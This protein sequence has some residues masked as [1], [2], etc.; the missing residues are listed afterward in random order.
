MVEAYILNLADCLLVYF[1]EDMLRMWWM[2]EKRRNVLS[3]YIWSRRP[4]DWISWCFIHKFTPW[5]DTSI[6]TVTITWSRGH[7]AQNTNQLT[8]KLPKAKN[9]KSDDFLQRPTNDSP[10]GIPLV[11]LESRH[12][13]RVMQRSSFH[14][15]H[16]ECRCRTVLCA[17]P[18]GYTS[19][20]SEDEHSSSKNVYEKCVPSRMI[21][22]IDHPQSPQWLENH[23]TFP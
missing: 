6:L 11:A 10:T 13:L 22:G 3:I 20:I 17:G 23:N 15:F 4:L 12:I 2:I 7:E 5:S 21:D 14:A 18:Y 1:G 9:N 16:W 19:S 8:Q